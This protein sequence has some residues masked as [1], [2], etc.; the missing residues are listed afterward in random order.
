MSRSAF[1]LLRNAG[2]YLLI[3]RG[4][5]PDQGVTHC[6]IEMLRQSPDLAAL[7]WIAV[8]QVESCSGVIPL[9]ARDLRFRLE[10]Y[11]LPA[12]GTLDNMNNVNRRCT[13]CG[14]LESDHAPYGP[15]KPHERS[16][17][18]SKQLASSIRWTVY[19]EEN[20]PYTL[21]PTTVEAY[22]QVALC[23]A[24]LGFNKPH[25]IK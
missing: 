13:V 17:L 24:C 19:P 16:S 20:G 21:F 8:L 6:S 23:T 10:H 11:L 5:H 7:C 14:H 12:T 4:F 2:R 1:N 22:C 3:S 25:H 9:W 18:Y 15:K